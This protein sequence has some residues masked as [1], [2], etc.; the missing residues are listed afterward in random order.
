[1]HHAGT[2]RKVERLDAQLLSA[3]RKEDF[4]LDP[5]LHARYSPWV[6]E[7]QL[8]IQVRT[9]GGSQFYPAV[10]VLGASRRGYTFLCRDPEGFLTEGR[11]SYYP[12]TGQWSFTPGQPS[13]TPVPFPI[14]RRGVEAA[15]L[16]CHS[17]SVVASGQR[18]VE[19]ASRLGIGCESCHG[20]A[21]QH[22]QA[23]RRDPSGPLLLSAVH[24]APAT[25]Q[26][27]LCGSCHRPPSDSASA[28]ESTIGLARFQG[29]AL[30]M[31]AC[32]TRSGGR[33][34]C[35][36][37]HDP[38]ADVSR[39]ARHYDLACQSCHSPKAGAAAAPVC[40]LKRQSACASC[41]M[42]EQ[43]VGMPDKQVFRSHW[44]R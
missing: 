4:L 19:S 5:Y 38:H 30:A 11:I 13:E 22:V 28:S 33:L 31:S 15:C 8:G 41:H 34:T 7:G 25:G 27:A 14:G 32:F 39:D 3:F 17:T 9:A 1:T 36:T 37:C 40:R 20:P 2:V 26:V 42:Q 29:T 6:R 10:W 35:T 23:K 24:S 16:P 18:L 12:T 43:D 21:A 44:I